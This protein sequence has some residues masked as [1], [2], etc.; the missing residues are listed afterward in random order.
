MAIAGKIGAIYVSDIDTAPVSFTD[1]A[2]TADATYTRY[3]ITNEAYRYWPLDADITVEVNATPVTS[4]FTLE[5]AGGYVVFDSALNAE[6]VVTV[7]GEALT[8]VQCG[9]F[10]NWSVDTDAEVPEATTFASG[11]WKE[12]QQVLKGW[13]GSAEAYWGDDRFFKSLGEIIVVKLYVDSGA[14][15]KCLEG[16]VLINSEGIEAAIDSLVQETIDFQGV[17]PLYPR[18]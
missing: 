10:F 14:S 17:G 15:Q 3:Q 11:G 5:R 18:L 2:T 8:L 6:D 1:E 4:G 12:F 13:S 7:S 16:F 9:G